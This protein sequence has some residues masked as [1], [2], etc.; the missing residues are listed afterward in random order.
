MEAAL[1]DATVCFFDSL[2]AQ[3]RRLQQAGQ[4]SQAIA[5]L[6]RL[7]AFADLSADRAAEVQARLGEL[8]LKQRR[9]RKAR[10][11]LRRAL[12][13]APD[14]ARLHHRLGYCHGNDPRGKAE[15]AL[16]HYHRAIDLDPDRARWRSEGGLL[17][18]RL[19]RPEEG[20]ALLRQAHEQAPDDLTVLGRLVKGLCQ[21]GQSDE[22]LRVVRLARFRA[23]RCSRLQKLQADLLLARLRRTQQTEAARREASPVLLPFVR[24][25]V[26]TTNAARYDELH[27]LPGPHLVYVRARTGRRVP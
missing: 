5:I 25:E 9:Y 11:H 23:P 20:L 16:R 1:M 18:V 10:R 21:C 2:L 13:L 4:S 27:A 7:A 8:H 12:G 17:A 24:A 15:L 14:S 22:A 3:A 26:E 6:T 19:G